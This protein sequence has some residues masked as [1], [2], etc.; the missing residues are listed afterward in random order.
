M[1]SSPTNSCLDSSW[2]G[3]ASSREEAEALFYRQGD[4]GFLEDL[5]EGL[6]EYCPGDG[7]RLQCSKHLAYCRARNLVMDFRGLKDRVRKE[8]LR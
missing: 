6:Q 7:P 1:A 4:W 2:E 5:R 8:N 3:W